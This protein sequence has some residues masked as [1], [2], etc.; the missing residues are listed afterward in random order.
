MNM[1][2]KFNP[3]YVF[4][5]SWEVCN[6]VGGIHTVIATKAPAIAKQFRSKYILIGPDIWQH[7]EN[8]EFVENP[9]LF[10][11]W[12]AK[13]ASEGLR[14]RVGNW[15]IEGNPIVIL[16]DFSHYVSAK[17][18]VLR[19]YWDNY[20]LDSFNSPW[21]Y[22]ESVLFGYAV[23]KVIESFVKFNTASRENVICHFHEWM[24]GSALLYLEG[25]MP[26]IGSVFTTHATV[27]GRSIA[28]NGYPLY[29]EMKNYNPE[30]MAYRFG[31]QHKHFLE[32]ET[33][34]VAD[35]FTTVSEITAQEAQHFLSR[36]TDII[37]PNGFNDAIV[38]A[39]KDFDKKRKAARERLINVAQALVTQPIN[40][41]TKIVAISGRYEFRNKGIDAFI[42]ALGAL[43]RNPKNKKE[44]L[45]YILIPTAYDAP[46]Q[47]LLNNLHHPEQTTPN[48]QKHLTH[49]LPDVYNDAIVKRINE[50]QL[51][52]R[53][54][55]K[56]KV[57]FCPSYLNGNDGVFNLSYYD[58]LIG[59]DGT[60]FPSY[61]EPWGYTPLE[62]LAFKVPTITTNLAGF[63]KWV[64]DYY[65]QKQKAIE[66]VN[67]TDSNYG[68]V[69][70]A[71]VK[72]IQ[73]LL[74]SKDDDFQALRETAGKVSEI[75]LWKNL[76]QYYIKC[77]ELTLENIEDRV[78][79]LPPVETDGVAYLEKSK[80]VNTPNWRSVI[81]HRAI[82]EALQP[83][84]E[85]AKNLWWCW[86]D[87]AYEVF[88]YIDKAKWI[89]V[90]KNPIALLD[91]ISLSRYK[92]LEND[93]V[94][95]RN[96]SKVYGD[97]Q[98]YM[99]KKA[100][101]VS[102]SISYFSMEYGLH[103][104]LKIY[105][106][107]LGI[108]AG[109]YLKEAS[110]KA[111]KITGVGLLYRYGY[112]TQKLSS[113]GNQ[114]ADYEAQD[115]SKIP[116]TPVFD[117]ETGKWIVI[118]IELPGRTLYA[119]VWRVDVGRI[120]LYLLDTDFEN[121]R[122]DDRSITHH[123]Y[124]GDWENRLKQEM[125]L[126]LG[127]IKMLRK[128][129]IN[130][131]IYHCNEGHAAFIGLERLS[132]FIEHNNLT[133]SEAMEV[134][135]ASS[136][137]TTHTPVPA[138]HDAFEEGLLRAYLGSYTDKLHV[139][140]EQILALG[141]I[142]LSNP[143][144]KFSMS[145]L[146]ANLS[147]EVNGVSWLHGEVSKDILK[148][149]WPGYMP[150]EL[151]I[152][153]VTNGVH[154]PTWTAGLWKEVE[155][156]VF[157]KDYKTHHYDP[158]S[159]EGIYKVSDQRVWEIKTALRSKLLRRVEQKLRLEKNTPYFSPRQLVE[160]KEN[161]RED[162]LTIGFAR[163]FATYKRAHL[164]FTNIER[165]DRIINN[166]E[167]PVQFIFAGKAH[168]A[169]K[170]GQDLIKNIVE[171]SKLPQ[172]LGKI[173]FIPNYDMELARHMVQGVDVWMNTPTRPLEASGTSGEKAAMNGTMHF[174]VLD[175]WWVEGYREDAGWALPMERSYEN[176]Q[177]QDEMDAETIYNIIEDEIA[178]IFYDKNKDGISSRWCALI[179]NTIA[180][181]AV[182]FTT[183][184]MLTDY[185]NQYYY[186][187][188]ER[189][190]KLKDNKFATAIELSNWK[191]KVTQE[192]D[193]IKVA[194]FKVPNRNEQLISIGKTYKG[195][196]TLELG[197]LRPEDVGVELVV[198]QQKD[199]KFKVLSTTEF[200][201]VAQEGNKAT[202]QLEIASEYPGAL[203]L[204]IR[205]FPK[206]NL[207]PHR[208]DFALVKWL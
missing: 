205:I 64:N 127:G 9:G 23:G 55:D 170:A 95:M 1:T 109:D 37:T 123:L 72:N 17:N 165:L 49:I 38:P 52:N 86:N 70:G 16:V 47:G 97:F 80:V 126:G 34:K 206:N 136:L 13:A 155:N 201:V 8:K 108:L 51:F 62:S 169:D 119:R 41:N 92:E 45:A 187:M 200:T 129:G 139:N 83:L 151:H 102:P 71:I 125:L 89:E 104:S 40:E 164:L 22:V 153:Y 87:E 66:V 60:A 30:E 88:K 19:Y 189:V 33:T 81:I 10:K 197:D 179:K 202:Y 133:F 106:G 100:E 74:D 78:E 174:S 84:E 118:S 120:E 24:T 182:N 128:L 105:S 141:K 117:P 5:T 191:R 148:D 158:K 185:E 183:T 28:G 168:P 130:S 29:N 35:C 166:P 161:L 162:I 143:H 137:F 25:E 69:V 145:N 68:E 163:R 31:V 116:V 204:A 96:L 178:P 132:E 4:E 11:S 180:K 135:R 58:L 57:I 193:N 172:F 101:M 196:I 114:E 50:Q 208:Q 111:T 160:I 156:E 39:E 54:E 113:A 192:W 194:D 186:P 195:E 184:R 61:Y 171:I 73:N 79:S 90:R 159:F 2:K 190:T 65:P 46:N 173:L 107:G 146:A 75:A 18:E 157:G 7:N 138:G 203:H 144:E 176:Q 98:E 124:G 48:E 134:V 177:Y 85:L 76:V 150:E 142:N 154:Q 43:N 77:Y 63:G 36:K 121:N 53:K 181:V 115:F 27:V 207:L 32:K 82:P 20:K 198:A 12:R 167:R 21:D 67:R 152:S 112:F 199:D 140:W 14:V 6:K 59:L 110:D 149:L 56:V 94:F 15:K 44:L 147:Q 131:D 42:D 91:S 99:A 93:A 188:T 26:K 3:D 175:G 122:E 103:S